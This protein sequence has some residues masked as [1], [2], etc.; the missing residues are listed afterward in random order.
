MD[1]YVER[2]LG[3]TIPT[4]S[5]PQDHQHLGHFSLM[6]PYRQTPSSSSFFAFFSSSIVDSQCCA[7]FCCTAKWP[8][9]TYIYTCFFFISSPIMLYPKRLYTPVLY[10]RPSLP[11]HS[12]CNSLHLLT[13]NSQ[14]IPFP[15]PSPL[16]TTSLF[17][18]FVFFLGLYPW[19][20]EVPRLGV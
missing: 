19:H 14:S 13:P 8:S 5:Q 20:M 15:L 3:S 18:S 11:I 6:L 9:H 17:L 1:N 12:K 4:P 16:A 10:S 2:E 7:N